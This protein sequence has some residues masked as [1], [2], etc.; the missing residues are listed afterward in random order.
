[1]VPLGPRGGVWLRPRFQ[2]TSGVGRVRGVYSQSGRHGWTGP[3]ITPIMRKGYRFVDMSL[4]GTRNGIVGDSYYARGGSTS[5]QERGR[6]YRPY[7]INSPKRT[8]C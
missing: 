7:H 6:G 4:L 2:D 8:V 1:M 3:S 5:A